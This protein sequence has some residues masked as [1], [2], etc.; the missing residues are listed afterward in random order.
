M[1]I[2]QR[3]ERYTLEDWAEEQLAEI[4]E[5][6]FPG[7]VCRDP[8]IRATVESIC[9]LPTGERVVV[10]VKTTSSLNQ[11]LGEEHSDEIPL[12]WRIQVECEMTAANLERCIVVVL[13]RTTCGVS[14]YSVPRNRDMMGLMIERAREFWGYVRDDLTPPVSWYD[15]DQALARH[16]YL[17]DLGAALDWTGTEAAGDWAAYERLGKKIK[18]LK[19]ERDKIHAE[20][21]VKI[22]DHKRALLGDGRE[23]V[24]Q[25]IRKDPYTVYPKPY[26]QLKAR[27]VK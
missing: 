17:P 18:E 23:I 27:K 19:D 4:L 9:E 11:E 20:V 7:I 21:V 25:E 3:L 5:Y 12:A 1:Q 14:Q 6:Q 24:V 13:D 2:G 22:G 26:C 16:L 8:E 15:V 10:E